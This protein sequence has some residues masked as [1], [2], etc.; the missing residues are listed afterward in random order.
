MPP[1]RARET[2]AQRAH[3]ADA[4]CVCAQW[5]HPA[6]LPPS[7]PPTAATAHLPDAWHTPAPAR[8]TVAFAGATPPVTATLGV[9]SAVGTCTA[10]GDSNSSSS[11]SGGAIA[12]V[13]GRAVCAWDC[14]G[15]VRALDW[16]SV[17]AGDRAALLGAHREVL[18]VSAELH[19]G[20]LRES[21]RTYRG[22]GAIQLW[23]LPC[24][25][26][27]VLFA[28]AFSDSFP[29]SHLLHVCISRDIPYVQ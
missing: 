25:S 14:G 7:L 20:T 10:P 19:A 13:D 11:E 12:T 3:D 28:F 27:T 9:P 16:A 2:A 8:P 29:S 6:A 21:G 1:T 24:D 18:A 17:R 26:G 15:A 23:S 5:A 22:P 4:A